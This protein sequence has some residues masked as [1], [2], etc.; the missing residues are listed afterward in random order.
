M[1]SWKDSLGGPD[2]EPIDRQLARLIQ[3]LAPADRSELLA[4]S[5]ALV[6]RGRRSGHSCL[7]LAELAGQILPVEDGPDFPALPD[8]RTWRQALSVPEWVGEGDG[9]EPLVLADDRLYLRRDFE[10]ER[11]VASA[12]R[13]RLD[14][15]AKALDP[16]TWRDRIAKAFPERDEGPNWQAVAV[17]AALRLPFA[18]ITG[19]PGTGK[20][21]TV[22]K[23][24][25]LVL[26]ESPGTE[27][28]LAAPT[29]KAATRLEE[30]IQNG[31]ESVPA[32]V[33]A[34]IPQKVVTLHRLL[35]MQPRL[36]RFL[37]GPD[38]PLSADLVLVDEASMVDSLLMDA[39][40]A[41]LPPK[42]GLILLGDPD[43]LASVDSGF[44]LGDLCAA[45][46]VEAGVSQELASAAEPLLDE[47]LPVNEGSTGLSGSVV[48]LRRNYR[49]RD[50]PGI[51][52]LSEAVRNRDFD[53]ALAA[54]EEHDD[55]V[56]LEPPTSAKECL[57]PL[58]E[59][60]VEA[61]GPG[62]PEEAL[63]RFGRLRVL[64]G[65]R[66]GPIGVVAFNAAVERIL[67]ETGR[68][69]P[70]AESY[71]GRPVLVTTND[72]QTQLFNGDVGLF[73]ETER[74]LRVFFPSSDGPPRSLSPAR[75]PDHET[76]WAMT[77]HKSQ[78]S[79]FDRVLLVMPPIESP[80]CTRELLYTG[81]TRA[82][83][84][85]WLVASEAQIREALERPTRRATGLVEALGGD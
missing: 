48:R 9:G 60:L 20:T 15:P 40:F 84:K 70:G 16:S 33:R 80:L 26:E 30:S 72:Y 4:L 68:I 36:Q 5:A 2:F 35:G 79:E 76:A 38:S 57:A 28:A 65:L 22:L 51:G 75:L 11:R 81:I 45:A 61:T 13:A 63:F 25:S 1:S 41:A 67:A 21:T 50:Q 66:R 27:I 10:A 44:V 83:K 14:G 39:L 17:I 46:D 31:L 73:R 37:R 23:L 47:A 32:S 52:A 19:G 42:A 62:T 24:L 71:A 53:R 59:D 85:V 69:L 29:G 8:L 56:R 55:I 12:I 58:L 74:G 7:R 54:L 34:L 64:S 78:G 3:R 18:V 77:V 6:S 49:F 82:R 43:Q